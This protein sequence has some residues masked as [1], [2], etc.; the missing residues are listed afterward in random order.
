MAAGEGQLL[1]RPSD[2]PDH[3]AILNEHTSYHDHVEAVDI[4]DDFHTNPGIVPL[5]NLTD[6]AGRN[7]STLS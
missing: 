2:W 3:A 4:A 5:K 7:F 1:E 6:L